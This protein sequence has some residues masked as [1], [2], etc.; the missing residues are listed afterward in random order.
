M[1]LH[2]D[3]RFLAG[4][5]AGNVD[6]FD[7]ELEGVQSPVEPASDSFM[8]AGDGDEVTYGPAA[9]VSTHRTDV[10]A[11]DAVEL[12]RL[13][14]EHGETVMA[15]VVVD[16]RPYL[17]Y[18]A[19]HIVGAHNVCYPSLLER[20]R[21]RRQ[22]SRAGVPPVPLEYIIRSEETRQALVEGRCQR[23]VVHDEDTQDIHWSEE[24]QTVSAG[25]LCEVPA[26]RL[27]QLISVLRSLADST[28]CELHFL[29]GELLQVQPCN[30]SVISTICLYC[31]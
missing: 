8:A 13:L 21:Q 12:S 18:S 19:S 7:D 29:Q 3:V 24:V 15:T 16:C 1:Q 30:V 26:G 28:T 9:D 5:T 2:Q 11:I 25:R 20:R 10:A 22:T 17:A 14:S 23:I 31:Q 27:S 6:V 4:D